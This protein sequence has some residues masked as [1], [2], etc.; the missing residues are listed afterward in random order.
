LSLA[1]QNIFD[2][3]ARTM[4][5]RIL[6]STSAVIDALG[7]NQAVQAIVPPPPAKRSLPKRKQAKASSRQRVSNWRRFATFPSYTYGAL[8]D[9]LIALGKTAPRSLWAMGDGM[10]DDHRTKPREGARLSA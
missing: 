2:Y 6:R 7:G 1:G 10:I 4:N 3:I 8:A 9:A 5:G